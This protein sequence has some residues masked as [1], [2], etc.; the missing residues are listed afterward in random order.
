MREQTDAFNTW[1]NLA[2]RS[3]RLQFE[4][5]RREDDGRIIPLMGKVCGPR[6]K[7][8]IKQMERASL[9]LVK[10]AVEQLVKASATREQAEEGVSTIL[11]LIEHMA[12]EVLAVAALAGAAD[13]DARTQV[14]S[15][16][17]KLKVDLSNGLHIALP[18]DPAA[19]KAPKRKRGRKIN[20][21]WAR[22]YA[23]A[24]ARDHS[25][26]M[27]FGDNDFRDWVRRTSQFKG[28]ASPADPRTVRAYRDR[29]ER[30][31]FDQFIGT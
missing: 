30:G 14:D 15:M 9:P 17:A 3:A 26:A 21:V 19:K 10:E 11:D 2:V 8:A 20:P 24:Y 23:L 29:A 7:A 28:Q 13:G 18:E 5:G 27:A 25:R 1:V 4:D 31:E 6:V 12:R 16:L 22:E